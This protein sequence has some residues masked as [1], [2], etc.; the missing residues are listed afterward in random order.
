VDDGFPFAKLKAPV[1]A[2]RFGFNLAQQIMVALDVGAAGRR[3]LDERKLTAIDRILLQE[4]LDRSK[5]L[6]NTFRGFP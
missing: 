3:D 1:D 2:F 4:Q 5:T 6:Q